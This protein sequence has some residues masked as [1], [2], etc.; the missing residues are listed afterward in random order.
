[1]PG[2]IHYREVALPSK[3]KA[4]VFYDDQL[5][6]LGR[7]IIFSQQGQ[8]QWICEVFGNPTDPLTQKR[9][10]LFTPLAHRLLKQKGWA[11]IENQ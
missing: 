8:N 7:L 6:E 11:L 9:R 3:R 2:G 5:G 4:Y 1:M 10:E